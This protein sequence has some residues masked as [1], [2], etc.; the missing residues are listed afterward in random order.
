MFRKLLKFPKHGQ[1]KASPLPVFYALFIIK[2]I[3]EKFVFLK[4]L[5]HTT[6]HIEHRLE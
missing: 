3:V 4:N 2:M 1:F 5:N 6:G